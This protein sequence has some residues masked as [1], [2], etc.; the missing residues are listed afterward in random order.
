MKLLFL[1]TIFTLSLTSHAAL[2]VEPL[3]GYN[4]N[5]TTSTEDLNTADSFSGT[6]YGGRLGWQN[7][8]FQ[9][10]L[11]YL[12]SS[13]TTKNDDQDASFQD[14][15]AFVGFK[16]PVFFRV[17]AGYIFSSTGECKDADAEYTKGSGSKVGIGFTGIPFININLEYRKLTYSE[18]N[19]LEMDTKVDAIMLGLSLP[20]TI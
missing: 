17:Y 7:F 5:G 10:G 20:L 3:V 2:L 11:D 14:W 6:S 18:Y 15:G 1:I 4:I 12:S 19:D 16:F 13:L 8:G 9:L